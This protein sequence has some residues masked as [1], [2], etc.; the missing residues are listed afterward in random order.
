[1]NNNK[2]LLKPIF[3]SFTYFN[4]MLISPFSYEQIKSFLNVWMMFLY[5]LEITLR[6]I[7][8]YHLKLN[9]F[10]GFSE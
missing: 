9:C 8:K 10:C 6:I 5:G 2:K 1:M 7:N 4:I 3:F